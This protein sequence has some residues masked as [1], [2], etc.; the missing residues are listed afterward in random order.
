MSEPERGMDGAVAKLQCAAG[1][2]LVVKI[3]SVVLSGEQ[4][5]RLRAHFARFVP[6]GVRIL[7]LDRDVDLSVLSKSEIESR[8]V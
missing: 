5:E 2:V 3:T 1:D 4:Q 6:A 7:V 8:A